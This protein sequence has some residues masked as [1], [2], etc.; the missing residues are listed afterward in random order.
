[1]AFNLFPVQANPNV[2]QIGW[3]LNGH[4][5]KTNS[6][7]GIEMQNSSL[8]VTNVNHDH[9]GQYQCFASNLLGDGQSE[10]VFLDVKCKS[11]LASNDGSDFAAS[12]AMVVWSIPNGI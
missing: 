7:S 9:Y 6:V 5:L 4:T 10:P 1:M 8:L 11:I 3:K 2:D 12:I